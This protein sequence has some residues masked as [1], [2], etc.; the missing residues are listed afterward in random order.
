[1]K[2]DDDTSTVPVRPR[3][4]GHTRSRT[5]SLAP[6][7]P[8]EALLLRRWALAL[9][10]SDAGPDERTW[11]H[12]LASSAEGWKLFL[13]RERCASPLQRRLKQT[14]A[15][16]RLPE[17]ATRE[18][19]TSALSDLKR[20]LSVRSHLATLAQLARERG[21]WIAVLK[22]GV[23]VAEGE[24]IYLADLDVLTRPEQAFELA[25]ALTALEYESTGTDRVTSRHLAAR[26]QPHS[27][28]VEIHHT[29]K[30]LDAIDEVRARAVPLEALPPLRQLGPADH[31]R[32]L[33]VHSTAQHPERAG[34]IRDLLLVSHAL[35]SCTPADLATVERDLADHDEA[36]TIRETIQ[37]ARALQT[38][39]WH[40][41]PFEYQALCGYIA[42]ERPK[43]DDVET[44]IVAHGLNLA[45]AR[46]SSWRQFLKYRARPS[47]IDHARPI[48]WLRRHLP[49]LATVAKDMI[50]LP[51]FLAAARIAGNIRREATR[52]LD[53]ME[54]ISL[55]TTSS[56][57][58][59]SRQRTSRAG[60]R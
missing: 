16:N 7:P 48:A 51:S 17:A 11:Q 41:D 10:G 36:A 25:D 49:P 26:F 14:G 20:V 30:V 46:R 34:R 47:S 2:Y 8:A 52:I 56:E 58:P 31:L 59:A 27:L 29:I 50:F 22:G 45:I 55:Q 13:A 60:S 37:A 12:A 24:Q 35:R 4:R 38:R 57:P 32:Y 43:R 5:M 53:S 54:R 9:L 40:A 15:I 44:H 19:G 33:L 28:P 42:F 21:W 18:L 1:M 3:I 39:A 23:A 6:N